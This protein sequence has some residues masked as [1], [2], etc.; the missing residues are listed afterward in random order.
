[1][2]KKIITTILLVSFAYSNLVSQI[3]II[4]NGQPIEQGKSFTIKI[5]K[6]REYEKQLIDQ[7]IYSIK[8]ITP[9]FIYVLGNNTVNVRKVDDVT[10]N[11]AFNNL[12]INE[13][14]SIVVVLYGYNLAN[15]ITNIAWR[16]TL[17]YPIALNFSIISFL[18]LMGGADATESI[19]AINEVLWSTNRP[20]YLRQSKTSFSVSNLFNN[21]ISLNTQLKSLPFSKKRK[22]NFDINSNKVIVES[23]VNL[24]PGKYSANNGVIIDVSL[25]NTLIVKYNGELNYCTYKI[26]D[27]KNF[28]II[29]S[30]GSKLYGYIIDKETFSIGSATYHLI[31]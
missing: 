4:N 12:P 24:R 3:C 26:Y 2:K 17:K 13:N 27:K 22:M 15:R 23:P 5:S 29:F 31:N 28:V 18:G 20:H 9:Q 25:N 21:Y 6:I 30:D 7:K 14:D 16:S 19:L 1:M 10:F 8:I 11:L